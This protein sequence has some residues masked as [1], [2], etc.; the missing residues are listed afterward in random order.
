MKRTILALV[1]LS[2]LV[3]SSRATDQEGDHLIY[4]GV[5][6]GIYVYPLESC[7]PKARGRLLHQGPWDPWCSANLRG[8]VATWE[9]AEGKL[10]L[11]KVTTLDDELKDWDKN[12]TIPESAFPGEVV[13]GRV[14]AKWFTGTLYSPGSRWGRSLPARERKRQ[15]ARS[16]LL[17]RIS[18]GVVVSVESCEV[19][20]LPYKPT[21][22][23]YGDSITAG[24][25]LKADQK[26]T[27]VLPELFPDAKLVLGAGI[28][29][30]TSRQGRSRLE[31]DMEASKA[32][33]L[34]LVWEEEELTAE[35][36]K[37]VDERPNLVV[38]FF[39]TNDSVLTGPGEFRVPA[40]EYRENLRQ[41]VLRCRKA[42]AETIICT[43]LPIIPEPYYTRHPKEFYDADGGLE[44]ILQAYRSAA[45]EVGK[46][47]HVPV[48]DL[49]EV[50]EKDMTLLRPA[51]DGVH[52]NARGAEV[53]AEEIARRLSSKRKPVPLPGD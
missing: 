7:N 45:K 21:I 51:P 30:N 46:E 12:N 8:Y 49:Y 3:S 23:C 6:H 44:K 37:L 9:I 25:H 28:G 17:I 41:M 5:S 47:L 36:K 13:D 18:N 40:E 11:T 34:R 15:E 2:C 48:V 19:P 27:A 38:L 33:L 31:R 16:R 14:H 1:V 26:Y 22:V 32:A 50:F 39:G 52:P 20:R 10:W 35:E 24:S 43:V 42:E 29:G 53:I 4:D